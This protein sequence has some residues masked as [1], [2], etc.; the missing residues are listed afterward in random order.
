MTANDLHRQLMVAVLLLTL[1]SFARAAEV[2][3]LPQCQ[4]QGPIVVLGDVAKV[5]SSDAMEV[6]RL[7]SLELMPAPAPGKMTYLR[8]R[9]IQDLLHARGVNLAGLHFSGASRVAIGERAARSAEPAGRTMAGAAIREAEQTAEQAIVDYL[10]RQAQE[11]LPWQVSLQ[12][13]P[14]QTRLLAGASGAIQVAG[15]T[16]PWVGQQTLTLTVPAVKGQQTLQV[17]AHVTVPAAVVVAVRPLARGTLVQVSDVELR[18]VPPIGYSANAETFHSLEAVV[19]QETS[20][21]IAA[22]QVLDRQYLQSPVLVRKGEVVTVYA[23]SAG[24][25]VRTTARARDAGSQGDLITVES[26]HDRSRFYARVAGP[27]VVEVYA[28]STS[29]QGAGAADFARAGQ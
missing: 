4:P 13:D 6:E 25:Q 28:R 15:G 10:T 24:I 17:A 21:A 18:A 8:I 3:L 19:G 9:E 26:L 27:Q 11:P 23:R 20:R 7:Q 16:A 29:I 22:G 5:L 2:R 1:T 12:L 14:Q